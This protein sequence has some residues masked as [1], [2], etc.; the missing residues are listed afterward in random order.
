MTNPYTTPI[1]AAVFEKLPLV[2]ANHPDA[3]FDVRIESFPGNDDEQ[4]FG[5]DVYTDA[6]RIN[7]TDRRQK[8][9]TEAKMTSYFFNAYGGFDGAPQSITTRYR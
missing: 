7:P 2:L 8:S 6:A 5:I 4:M 9:Y 3:A 1:P